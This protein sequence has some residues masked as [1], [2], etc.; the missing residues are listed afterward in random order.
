MDYVKLLPPEPGKRFRAWAKKQDVFV[1]QRALVYHFAWELTASGKKRR[2]VECHCSACGATYYREYIKSIK[3]GGLCGFADCG[4]AF[5]DHNRAT[6]AECG[7]ECVAL[8]VKQNQRRSLCYRDML[9]VTTR[10]RNLCL[11]FWRGALCFDAL[12]RRGMI[13]QRLYAAIFNGRRVMWFTSWRRLIYDYIYL[14][15]WVSRPPRSIQSLYVDL[16]KPFGESVLARSVLP[17]CK[18]DRYMDACPS[19]DPVAYLRLYQRHR[20]VEVMVVSGYS[21]LLCEM[22]GRNKTDLLDFRAKRLSAMLQIDKQA[23]SFIHGDCLRGL[24]VYRALQDQYGIRLSADDIKICARLSW[25]VS[26][27]YG[28]HFL[29]TLHY[30][31]RQD[32]NLASPRY[33]ADYLDMAKKLQYDLTKEDVLYPPDLVQAHNHAGDACKVSEDARMAAA[34]ETRFAALSRFAWRKDALIIFPARRQKDLIDEGAA[35]HHCVA[36]YAERHARGDTAIFFIRRT[37]APDE[38]F[39]TLEFDEKAMIVRQ[40]RGLRNC[41][42]TPEIVAFEAEWLKFVRKK[43]KGHGRKRASRAS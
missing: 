41:A 36:T 23:L 13:W 14:P 32:S 43:E 24:E 25:Q 12:G 42:R 6:C 33:Y 16:I 11:I 17:H 39:Y 5:Y 4:V 3:N 38:S 10:Q 7:A 8:Y 34:F 9:E 15:Q 18:L 35:L 28:P 37:G 2:A 22:I 40:D 30:L 1:K 31:S 21:E 29:R 19:A 20:N 26:P 27:I